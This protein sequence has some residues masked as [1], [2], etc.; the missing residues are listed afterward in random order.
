LRLAPFIFIKFANLIPER[1]RFSGMNAV[2]GP[3]KP[4][5]STTLLRRLLSIDACALF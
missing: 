4:L 5:F 1:R 2:S 3:K